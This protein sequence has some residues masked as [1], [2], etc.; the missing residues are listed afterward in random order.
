MTPHFSAAE[1]RCKC[2]CGLVQFQAGFLDHLELLRRTY[3]RYMRV[4]SACRCADHNAKVSP[5]APLR[6]LHIG[7]RETRPGHNGT[8]AIDVAVTGDDKGNLFAV[9]W[10]QGWSV[11]WNKNFLHLD[12][13]VDIG[14]P[15]VT[16]EY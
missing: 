8:L 13:R 10:K 16:F 2:G 6:S 14:M 12:R 9:A 1:L 5:Q 7:N 3:G 11:G 4:T 15:Q